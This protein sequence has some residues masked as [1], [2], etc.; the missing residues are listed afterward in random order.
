MGTVKCGLYTEV[1]NVVELT[2]WIVQKWSLRTG[3]LCVEVVFIANYLLDNG[4]FIM[5]LLYRNIC[6]IMYSYIILYYLLC[7]VHLGNCDGTTS[8]W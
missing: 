5:I 7:H 6:L 2:L 8:K 4:V 1:P 3:G